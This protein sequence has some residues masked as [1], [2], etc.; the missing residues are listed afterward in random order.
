V[1]IDEISMVRADMLDAVE[2][3]LRLNG[4]QPGKLFGGVQIIMVGDPLQLPPVVEEKLKE[5]F[6]RADDK[7]EGYASPEFFA[8]R[9]WE[10]MRPK[11]MSLHK[12]YRQED[13]AFITLLE[14]VRRGEPSQSVLARLNHH[15]SAPVEDE[16]MIALVGDNTSADT[17][18]RR[19]L[20]RLPRPEQCYHGEVTGRFGGA[21]G[22]LPVPLELCL[23]QGAWVIFAKNDPERRWVNGTP[24]IV[25]ELGENAVWVRVWCE[26]RPAATYEVKSMT[27]SDDDYEWDRELRVL[28]RRK[29]E[30][31]Y[32]QLPINLAWAITIHRSQGKT[33]KRMR[34]DPGGGLW[35]P[36]HVYTALSRL[37]TLE[38]RVLTRALDRG[39]FHVSATVQLFLARYGL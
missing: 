28:H 8:S 10:Q 11:V 34:L 4:P 33:L 12:I 22:K 16:R 39:D 36:G 37:R 7:G 25:E 23:R 17:I 31:S 6:N 38:G 21:K 35:A 5:Y 30:A 27:W 14:H 1:V 32:T 26:G 9:A 29:A 2:R 18:N 24:G 3:F 20:S 13:T 19:R 15:I